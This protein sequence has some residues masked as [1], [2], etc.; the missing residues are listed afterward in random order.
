MISC[1]LVGD[2]QRFTLLHELSHILLDGRLPKKLNLEMVCNRLAGAFLVPTSEVV[3]QLGNKRSWLE[4]RYVYLLK[5][6][7]GLS[8]GG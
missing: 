2:R 3:Q 7:R 8:T 4:S 1:E 5:H 6:E